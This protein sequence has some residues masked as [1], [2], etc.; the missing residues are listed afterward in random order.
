MNGQ[1]GP[2][3]DSF[4]PG[5]HEQN[6]HVPDHE[7]RIEAGAKKTNT[8]LRYVLT[9]GGDLIQRFANDRNDLLPG[10]RFVDA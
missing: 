4:S 2:P 9:P 10:E 8:R 7:V 6:P 1:Y 3:E 5:W